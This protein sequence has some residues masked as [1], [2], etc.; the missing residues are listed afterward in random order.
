LKLCTETIEERFHAIPGV[1]NVGITI[2]TPMEDNNWGTGIYIKGQPDSNSGASVVKTNSE[3]FDSG[4]TQVLTGRG[5][6][7]RDVPGAPALA[8]VNQEFAKRVFPGQ[9]PIERYFGP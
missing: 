3:Y 5:L 2:Y 1:K 4:G 6:S 8:V 9:N 7:E